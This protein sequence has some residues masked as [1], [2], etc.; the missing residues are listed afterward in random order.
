M[1]LLSL[2]PL[3][4]WAM[5]CHAADFWTA[6]ASQNSPALHLI[7]EGKIRAGDFAA[8][9]AMLR[10]KGPYV[11]TLFLY[12]PGG[13]VREALRIADMVRTLEVA[14][15]GPARSAFYPDGSQGKNLSI[16]R[17]PK[18]RNQNNCVCY[19]SCFLVWISG[20]HRKKSLLGIHRPTYDKAYF[21]SLSPDQAEAEYGK[22]MQDMTIFLDRRSVPQSLKEKMLSTPARDIHKFESPD[23]LNGFIPAYDE[24]LAARC[25][26][27]SRHEEDQYYD[28]EARADEKRATNAEMS[29]LARLKPRVNEIMLCHELQKITMRIDAFSR[30]FKID[31]AARIR[32]RN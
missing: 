21:A 20:V 31:Y 24:L 14:T 27:L 15:S 18:P 32:G 13:D 19:S 16:C 17:S 8:L 26:A 30:Y 1:R 3:L 25:G 11:E 23:E 7:L 5:S 10:D 12:S 29:A 22:V 6:R 9:K 2:V 4:F 28:L